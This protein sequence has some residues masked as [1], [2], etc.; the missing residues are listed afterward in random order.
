MGTQ[1]DIDRFD[2]NNILF[3]YIQEWFERE[4]L[5]F[6]MLIIIADKNYYV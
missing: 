6:R 4:A 3:D 2:P 1:A 5:F